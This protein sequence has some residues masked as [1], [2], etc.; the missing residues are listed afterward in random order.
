MQLI[1]AVLD[2]PATA[3]LE[4]MAFAVLVAA[5]TLDVFRR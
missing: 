4:L 3:K 1:Y 5:I 2:L